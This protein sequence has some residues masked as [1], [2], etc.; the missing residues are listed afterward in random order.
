MDPLSMHDVL[1]LDS[2]VDPI[3][4]LAEYTVLLRILVEV[5]GQQDLREIEREKREEEVGRNGELKVEE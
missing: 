2:S 5:E 3:S 1:E 4:L